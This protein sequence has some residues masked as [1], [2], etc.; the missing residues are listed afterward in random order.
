MSKKKKIDFL[1]MAVELSPCINLRYQFLRKINELNFKNK[2]YRKD[3]F[4]ALA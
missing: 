4:N 3:L 1:P 2:Y